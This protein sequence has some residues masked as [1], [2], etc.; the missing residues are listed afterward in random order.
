MPGQD[1]EPQY[2]LGQPIRYLGPNSGPYEPQ[3]VMGYP[4]DSLRPSP[5]DIEW[6]TSWLHPI[7]TYK[8]WVR[9]RRL[10]PY[11]DEP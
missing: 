7:R 1:E 5:A 10:G 11:D 3:R 9:R 4:I 2:I 8:R 6:F